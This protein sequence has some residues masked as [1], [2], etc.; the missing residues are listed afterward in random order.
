MVPQVS[1]VWRMEADATVPARAMCICNMAVHCLG[2][3]K[4]WFYASIVVHACD[5]IP[6]LLGSC[7]SMKQHA[8]KVVTFFHKPKCM[9]G[10]SCAIVQPAQLDMLESAWSV[11]KG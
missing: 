9:L 10:K 7:K 6:E 1:S 11:R 5:V 2:P 4:L 8:M 3:Q